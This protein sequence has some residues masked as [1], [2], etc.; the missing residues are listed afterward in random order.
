MCGATV[1]NVSQTRKE[2]YKGITVGIRLCNKCV[3]ILIARYISLV[4][5][6]GI[7]IMERE[8]DNLS[9]FGQLS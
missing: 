6:E 4:C 8:I 3:P 9:K 1:D 7:V 2:Q 5:N